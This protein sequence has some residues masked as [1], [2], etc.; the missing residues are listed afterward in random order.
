[1]SE[2]DT[3]SEQSMMRALVG[4]AGLGVV[5]LIIALASAIFSSASTER[6]V[7]VAGG[8][9][10]EAVANLTAADNGA[11]AADGSREPLADLGVAPSAASNSSAPAKR[12]K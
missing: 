3:T 5:V 8:A 6:P 2:R 7:A 1:M 9:K 12:A 4:V 11:Q 10:P